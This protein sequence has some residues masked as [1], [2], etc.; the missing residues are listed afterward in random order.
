[1]LVTCEVRESTNCVC[2]TLLLC[3]P[4]SMSSDKKIA[5][6]KQQLGEAVQRIETIQ[7][8]HKQPLLTRISSHLKTQSGSIVNVVL[9]ASLFAVAVGRLH[10]KRQHEV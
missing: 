2:A 5:E 1:M 10:Q 8:G 7:S 6:I 9:T 3:V 4:E